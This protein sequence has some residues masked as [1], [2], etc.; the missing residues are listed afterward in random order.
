MAD[1]LIAVA[2]S[3]SKIIWKL[4]VESWFR[5]SKVELISAQFS[6]NR[7]LLTYFFQVRI[8]LNAGFWILY[9]NWFMNFLFKFSAS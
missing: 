3:L 9:N 4:V 7:R 2:L 6:T 8:A 5:V 1:V